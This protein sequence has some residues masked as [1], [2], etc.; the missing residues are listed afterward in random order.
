MVSQCLEGWG[1][2]QGFE[3][4][5]FLDLLLMV[6]VLEPVFSTPLSL[7]SPH[8]T[9]LSTKKE[10]LG[11]ATVNS[12]H[13]EPHP[14]GP[15]TTEDAWGSLGLGTVWRKVS[16]AEG[17]LPEWHLH[18]ECHFLSAAKDSLTLVPFQI[19]P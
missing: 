8:P 5:T 18:P 9:N 15:M 10:H 12:D 13:W 11:P 14:D 3:M 17:Y 2:G 6:L 19:C 16:N 4:C 7:L 1:S